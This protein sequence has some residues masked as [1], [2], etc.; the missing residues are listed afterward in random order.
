MDLLL[1][2]RRLRHH[3]RN[4][5]RLHP[6]LFHLL[7]RLPHVHNRLRRQFFLPEFRQRHPLPQCRLR[8]RRLRALLLLLLHNRHRR[9]A[10][11]KHHL[12]LRLFYLHFHR[13]LHCPRHQHRRHLCNHLKYHCPHWTSSSGRSAVMH[14]LSWISWLQTYLTITWEVLAPTT[15][16]HL[17][18]QTLS[19]VLGFRRKEFITKGLELIRTLMKVVLVSSSHLICMSRTRRFMSRGILSRTG[20]ALDLAILESSTPIKTRRLLWSTSLWSQ[21]REID[22]HRRTV[23]QF[24]SWTLTLALTE[25]FRSHLRFVTFSAIRPRWSSST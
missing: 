7:L 25:F 21:K 12:R 1:P 9:Q 5:R 6:L 23:L 19:C 2:V 3:R 24:G 16:F 15:T 11:R 18:A 14:R 13:F 8:R 10:R 17:S 22:M 4:L 20:S